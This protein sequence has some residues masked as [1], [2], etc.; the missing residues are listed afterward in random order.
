MARVLHQNVL[1]LL[2][3]LKTLDTE[4]HNTHQRLDEM[5]KLFSVLGQKLNPSFIW[6]REKEEGSVCVLH[7]G[8]QEPHTHGP[9]TVDLS[10]GTMQSYS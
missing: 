2:K 10:E 7:T 6:Q 3:I 1:F 9:F 5:A 4:W 8:S